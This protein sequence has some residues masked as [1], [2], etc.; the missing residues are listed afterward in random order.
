[1]REALVNSASMS[2]LPKA[3]AGKPGIAGFGE[4]LACIR[5]IRQLTQVQLSRKT[6]L[7]PTALSHFECSGRRPS[8]ENLRRLCMALNCSAD[9]L[10][11]SH[12]DSK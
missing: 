9:Y 10:L 8:C 5:K 12:V 4:R 6:K 7:P 3:I 1:M 11:D 2:R